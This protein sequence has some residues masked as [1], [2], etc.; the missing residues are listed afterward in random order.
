MRR[1][2]CHA[3][4]ARRPRAGFTLVELLVVITI[5]ILLL[6]VTMPAIN[7]A[8]E[9]GRQVVCRGNLQNIGTA[10]VRYNDTN[11]FIP[12]WR[13]TPV[14]GTVQRSWTAM[15]MPFMD[16]KDIGDLVSGS[17]TIPAT[18]VGSFV[19]PTSPPDTQMASWLSYAGASSV[20]RAAGVMVE[21]AP[22]VSLDDVSASGGGDG[23]PTTLLL[24]EKCG[25]ARGGTVGTWNNAT[26]AADLR[27]G[28]LNGGPSLRAING[29]TSDAALLPSSSHAGG[30]MVAFCDG[31]VE[32]LKESLRKEVF[33]QLMS[34]RHSDA[35]GSEYTAFVGS[36]TI[37]NEGDYK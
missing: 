23:Q 26:N 1:P 6:G 24:A 19:C 13:M 18:Y 2:A 34:W 10:V 14:G 30:A 31:H 35:S 25:S 3:S 36:Y 15:I 7:A 17:S 21:A 16:R 5:I 9:Q 32:F 8:R 28:I 37:L 4:A 22:R 11:G 12:G 20:Q 27:F 29:N 33:A